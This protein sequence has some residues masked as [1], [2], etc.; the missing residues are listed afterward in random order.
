MALDSIAI[1]RSRYLELEQ[2]E[3]KIMNV[4]FFASNVLRPLAINTFAFMHSNIG[5]NFFYLCV[6]DALSLSVKVF[7]TLIH[8][9]NDDS[10]SFHIS[11]SP[12]AVFASRRTKR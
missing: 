12:P 3:Q 5:D 2:P 4:D 1:F 8:K 11:F 6:Y 9:S 10:N 7:S